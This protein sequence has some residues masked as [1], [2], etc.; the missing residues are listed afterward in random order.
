MELREEAT[1]EDA[2]EV[3]LMI[4]K[5]VLIMKI[6]DFWLSQVV[7]IMRSSM[8]DTFSDNIGQLDFSRSMMG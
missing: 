2:E 8:I 4:S 6:G 5:M 1:K 7:E 3:I